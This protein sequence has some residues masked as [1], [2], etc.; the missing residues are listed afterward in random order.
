[1]VRTRPWVRG[2]AA[3]VGGDHPV[4]DDVAEVDPTPPVAHCGVRGEPRGALVTLTK[5]ALV[6][7]PN[8]A[9]HQEAQVTDEVSG[10]LVVGDV[11]AVDVEPKALPLEP[12][13]V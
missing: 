5:D 8:L 7:N 9:N 1:L 10:E 2:S 13:P 11:L 4:L 3:G 6:E 12:A